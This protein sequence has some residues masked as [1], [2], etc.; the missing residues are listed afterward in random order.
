MFAVYFQWFWVVCVFSG[1]HGYG[2]WMFLGD[3][4]VGLLMKFHHVLV[5]CI[6]V[7]PVVV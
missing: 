1:V 4:G 7:V 2:L 3:L 6:L 5:I